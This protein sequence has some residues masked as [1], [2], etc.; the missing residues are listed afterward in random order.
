[1]KAATILELSRVPLTDTSDAELMALK[2]RQQAAVMS[3]A[4]VFWILTVVC[5]DNLIRIDCGRESPNVGAQ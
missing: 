1:M 4:D 2:L 3:Y 5:T